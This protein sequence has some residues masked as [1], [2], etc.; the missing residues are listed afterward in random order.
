MKKNYHI[1]KRKKRL[2][3]K[4]FKRWRDAWPPPSLVNVEA[5][6]K[7]LKLSGNWIYYWRNKEKIED[8]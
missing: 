1:K 3:K 8:E 2:R 7:I 5:Y 6:A 4:R